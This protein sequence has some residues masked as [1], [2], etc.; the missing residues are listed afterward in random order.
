MGFLDLLSKKK[1][2]ND[3]PPP[4]PAPSGND[5]KNQ[6]NNSPAG[7]IPPGPGKKEDNKPSDSNI[8][9]GP[10]VQGN[11][12]SA[13]SKPSSNSGEVQGSTGGLQ[14]NPFSQ[15]DSLSS[16]QQDNNKNGITGS[17]DEVR[18]GLPQG[19]RQGNNQPSK[20]AFP[21]LDLP[22]FPGGGPSQK[23]GNIPDFKGDFEQQNNQESSNSVQ[24]KGTNEEEQYNE[25]P[26]MS[27]SPESRDSAPDRNEEE[28]VRSKDVQPSYDYYERLRGAETAASEVNWNPKPFYSQE[29]SQLNNMKRQLHKNLDDPSSDN[30]TLGDVE[31]RMKKKIRKVN[32]PLFVEINDYKR[33]LNAVDDIK[34][35]STE[36][37][38]FI[39]KLDEFN[40]KK[41]TEFEKWK[42]TIQYINTKLQ[43]VD[44]TLFNKENQ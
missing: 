31:K 20:D 25:V 36:S 34:R 15:G 30:S 16:P 14:Q 22:K 18:S 13:P 43:F 23:P 26:R 37:Q 40:D 9:P 24:P 19:M 17:N 28:N 44:N 6:G 11:S 2:G 42:K 8:P 33:V 3:I 1:K 32:G 29:E 39:L 12:P 21:K 5:A 41:H 4:A 7:S 38:D 10:A 35:N 27:P